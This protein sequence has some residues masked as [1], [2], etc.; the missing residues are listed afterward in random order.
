MALSLESGCDSSTHA[1]VHMYSTHAPSPPTDEKDFFEIITH[2]Q[3]EVANCYKI[4]TWLRLPQGLLKTISVQTRDYA[5]AMNKI[6]TN[7]LQQNYDTD[8]HGLPTWKM[9]ADA[10]RAPTG[11]NNAK[12]ANEIA[13]AHPAKGQQ[14]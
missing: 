13:K 12:L 8:V 2:L 1:C 5:E 7:W 6:I 11:G 3:N 10:V 4:G 14:S 9:L